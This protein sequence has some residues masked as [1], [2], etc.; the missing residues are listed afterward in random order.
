M[1]LA[2]NF[3][4][5][6]LRFDAARI[7]AEIDALPPEAW[8]P[9]PQKIPGNEA[10]RLITSRGEQNDDMA[11]PMAPTD[12]LRACP[13]ILDVMATIGATWGRSRLMRLTPQATVPAHV[14]IHYYWRTHVRMHIPIVTTPDVQFTCDD[15][16][17]HMAA[18]E[19][20]MLDTW[21]RHRVQNGAQPRTHLVLDTTGGERLWQLIELAR[22]QPNARIAKPAP[23]PILFERYDTSTI[24]SPWEV[25]Y[26]AAFIGE[27]ATAHPALGRVL[28]RLEQLVEAW[29]AIWMQ[30]G[31]S[32]EGAPHYTALLKGFERDL[33][34]LQGQTISLRNQV[35]LYRILAE[36]VHT[37]GLPLQ[38]SAATVSRAA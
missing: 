35:P 4:R 23:L 21:R 10:V 33:P 15:E 1:R 24:M 7:A 22:A 5:L 27:Q 32:P 16:T 30:Y 28:K 9:H 34:A 3:L 20:W 8:V 36:L 18:G 37:L 19:C 12:Y 6:P 14:D 11:S 13:A 29:N 38:N 17:I 25:R 31:P 2:E 26:H